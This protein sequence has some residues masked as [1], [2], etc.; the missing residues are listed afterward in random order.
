MHYIHLRYAPDIYE[1]FLR[2]GSDMD[3][4]YR[5]FATLDIPE[6]KYEDYAWML[7][8]N[9]CNINMQISE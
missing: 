3:D 5:R 4:N 1:I 8:C 9:A 7:N 2:Y 6:I